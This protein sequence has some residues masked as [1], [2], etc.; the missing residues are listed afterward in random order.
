MHFTQ[1]LRFRRKKKQT[2]HWLK[3]LA[4]PLA[5]LVGGLILTRKH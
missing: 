1:Y 2:K 5:L 4:Y 3:M